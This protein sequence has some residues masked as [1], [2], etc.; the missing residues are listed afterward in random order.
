MLQSQLEEQANLLEHQREMAAASEQFNRA[1]AGGHSNRD[2]EADAKSSRGA[3][4]GRKYDQSSR[5]VIASLEQEISDLKQKLR[6][7]EK[8]HESTKEQLQEALESLDEMPRTQRGTKSAE[9]GKGG[10]SLSDPQHQELRGL[11][12]RTLDQ[13]EQIEVCIFI[14]FLMKI[15]CIFFLVVSNM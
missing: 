5:N 4:A 15:P 11:R 9:K 2:D 14:Y 6:E 12:E 7:Q 10:V 13:Q 1:M 3:T 8:Q